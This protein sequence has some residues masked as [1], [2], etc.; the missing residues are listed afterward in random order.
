MENLFRHISKTR[1]SPKGQNAIILIIVLTATTLIASA[2]SLENLITANANA[3]EDKKD[4]TEEEQSSNADEEN[5]NLTEATVGP[6][7]ISQRLDYAHFVP[8]SP[9]SNSPGNQ[10]KILLDYTVD[11]SSSLLEEPIS[12]V[13]EVYAENGTLLRTSSLPEP[14]VLHEPEGTVQ[15]ATTFDDKR[16]ESVTALALLTDETKGFPISDPLET[17]LNLGE[18]RTTDTQH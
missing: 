18:R 11:E 8:M 5:A 14:I 4:A 12:A 9:V 1:T 10:L 6:N 13:M 2:L 3:Q 16:L 7:G 15:L 17:R